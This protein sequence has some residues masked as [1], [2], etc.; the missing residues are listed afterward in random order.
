M[1]IAYQQ[2]GMGAGA[3][4]TMVFKASAGGRQ[5]KQDI[6]I[7]LAISPTFT[8]QAGVSFCQRE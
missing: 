5:M 4:Y 7:T 3:G 6:I 2:G 1:V 8:N